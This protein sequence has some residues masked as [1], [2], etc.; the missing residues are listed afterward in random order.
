MVFRRL[1]VILKQIAKLAVSNH[2]K[3]YISYE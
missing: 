1:K 3:L 2:F